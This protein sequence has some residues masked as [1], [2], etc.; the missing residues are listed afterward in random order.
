[1]LARCVVLLC[2]FLG[3]DATAAELRAEHLALVVNKNTPAGRE[4]AEFYA[5]TRDVPDGRIIELD[6][7][8][9]ERITRAD[10]EEKVL[11]P[12]RAALRERGLAEQ[13]R[14]LVTFHG[15][16]L[17]VHALQL[18]SAEKLERQEVDALAR[19]AVEAI[20]PAVEEAANAAAL[21]GVPIPAAERLPFG[22]PLQKQLQR[23]E[24][25]EKAITAKARE[26][27]PEEQA[28]LAGTFEVIRED[29]Q[30]PAALGLPASDETALQRAMLRPL[31]AESRQEARLQAGRG[32]SILLAQ[33]VASHQRR[34]T[35]KQTDAAFDSEL[36]LLWHEGKQTPTL[37]LWQPNPLRGQPSLDAA[38]ADKSRPRPMLTSRL[39]GPTEQAVRS[40]IVESTVVEQVGLTGTIVIDSRGLRVNPAKP[41]GYAPF[42]Q[43]LRD[44]AAL[45][46]TRATLPV[47][48]DDEP[49]VM[50]RSPDGA[51]A[52]EDVAVYV[53]WYQVRKYEDAFDF[54]AGAVGYHVASFELRTIRNAA[55]AT[56]AINLLRDGVVATTGPVN[57]PY[58]S[59]FPPPGQF[60]PLLLQGDRTL[61]EVYWATVP[62][63]SWMMGLIG[64]PLYRPFAKQPGILDVHR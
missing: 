33:V 40:L 55:S 15:V 32:P 5:S 58:L 48:H 59:A 23:L 16:P 41:D 50:R 53:G 12:V 31:D 27:S 21:L 49:G 57:E 13:V 51:A 24:I 34:L 42:D 2:L 36:A 7:P 56:W 54:A 9:G 64:D 20:R 29:L 38:F 62:Q 8:R 4:L 14:C 45:L 60:V 25:A 19:Q 30:R 37:A 10:F 6:L 61:A 52:V 22:T 28:A 43:Q 3:S 63:T 44:L 11:V 35:E 26:L 17:A 46:E 47:V 1:M 39:D 18:T